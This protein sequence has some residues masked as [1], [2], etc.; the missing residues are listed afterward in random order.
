MRRLLRISP[1]FLIAL[2]YFCFLFFMT[3][4]RWQ[5]FSPVN[6]YHSYIQMLWNTLRGKVL[7]YNM[8]RQIQASYFSFHFPPFLILIAPFYYLVEHPLT[9]SFAFLLFESAALI[10]VYFLSREVLGKSSFAYLATVV[11]A[12]LSSLCIQPS[13]GFL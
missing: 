11:F 2:A 12:F 13:R 6:D 9:L 4:N 8:G 1:I 10:P 3:F 5:A 7:F